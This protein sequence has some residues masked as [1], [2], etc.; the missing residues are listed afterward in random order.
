MD[1]GKKKRVGN[2]VVLKYKKGETPVIRVND[3]AGVWAVEFSFTHAMFAYIDSLKDEKSWEPVHALFV[4]W[5]GVSSIL[6]AQFVKDVYALIDEFVKREAKPTEPTQE[7]QEEED[8]LIAAE[9]QLAE[10]QNKNED[11]DE[12]Q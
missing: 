11:N 7:E 1:F 3:A 8:A 5:F 4:M 12:V 2:F 10:L 9:E 6:N